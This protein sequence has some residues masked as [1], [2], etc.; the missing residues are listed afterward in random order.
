M[1]L[2][3]SGVYRYYSILKFEAQRLLEKSV[4]LPSYESPLKIPRRLIQLLAIRILIPNKPLRS[5][6]GL[7]LPQTGVV[8]GALNKFGTCRQWRSELFKIITFHIQQ[9]YK[10]VWNP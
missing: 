7:V 2:A 10:V 4:R 5:F 8:N 3:E 1:D 9:L 6:S